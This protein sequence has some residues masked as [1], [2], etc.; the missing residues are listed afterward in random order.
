[1]SFPCP[2]KRG[3]SATAREKRNSLKTKKIVFLDDST[4][5]LSSPAARGRGKDESYK[6]NIVRH[7]YIHHALHNMELPVE[8]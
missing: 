7:K 1:M 8:R 6:S 5:N 3:F 4:C 2:M